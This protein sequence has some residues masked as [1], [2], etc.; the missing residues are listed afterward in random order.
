MINEG[1]KKPLKDVQNLSIQVTDTWRN[2]TEVIQD[3]FK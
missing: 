3:V 2:E 1:K